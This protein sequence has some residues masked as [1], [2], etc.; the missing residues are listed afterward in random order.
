MSLWRLLRDQ[1]AARAARADALEKRI[2]ALE[3]QIAWLT[4]NLVELHRQQ[5]TSGE[6][7]KQ[8]NA[9]LSV[10]PKWHWNT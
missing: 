6:I 2:A 1:W 7:A 3:S 4:E 5:H 9:H 8:I 10:R